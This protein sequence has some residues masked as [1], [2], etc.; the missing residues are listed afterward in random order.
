MATRYTDVDLMLL[1]RW[2]EVHALRQA[3]DHLLER[4][5]DVVQASLQKVSAHFAER[6]WAS[7]P[8]LKRP[9]MS[10]WKRDWANRRNEPGVYLQVFDFVPPDCGKGVADHPS[11]WL[12]TNEWA[13]L[14]MRESSD[15]FGRAVRTAL[16]PEMQARWRHDEADLSGHP[17]GRDCTDISDSDRVTLVSDPER[18][19]AFVIK[20]A[21]ELM[22]LAPAIDQVLQKMTRR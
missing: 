10:F 20:G 3:F 12:M 21:D 13:N 17:L 18:L 4:I 14:R 7:E 6:G 5:D 1:K 22:E 15:D 19:A 2:D 11:L 8:D 9:S 16:T